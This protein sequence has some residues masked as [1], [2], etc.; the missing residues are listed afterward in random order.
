MATAMKKCKV[1]GAEYEYCHTIRS[2]VAGVFRWQDVAC[3]QEHGSIY[4]ARIEAS[5]SGNNVTV[6]DEEIYEDLIDH[7]LEIVD[8]EDDD[9]DF[10]D[11]CDE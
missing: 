11:D 5:R 1:C 10:C 9:D 4:L 2:G 6:V 8:E 7:V 3:C